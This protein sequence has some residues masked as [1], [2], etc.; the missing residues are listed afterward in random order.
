MLGV[1]PIG[2]TAGGPDDWYMN[3]LWIDRRK[4]LLLLHA[5]TAFPI[6]IA[7]VRKPAMTP[8]APWLCRQIAD[9]LADE[10]LPADTL[11]LLDPSQLVVAKTDSRQSLGFMNEIAFRASW[12][13]ADSGGLANADIPHLNR[14][15]RQ[16]L[17]TYSGRYATPL[18]LTTRL[19]R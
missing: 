3:L 14:N 16:D 6:F 7:D 5:G 9:A 15:L 11:G 19:R 2:D 12:E 1:R 4:S 10:N 13:I 18:E 17:H 8:L